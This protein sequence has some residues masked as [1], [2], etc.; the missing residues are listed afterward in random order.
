MNIS[1]QL[2]Q[3]KETHTLFYFLHALNPDIGKWGGRR[4]CV[5]DR[6]D[7]LS[8]NDIVKR[9]DAVYKTSAKD[10]LTDQKNVMELIKKIKNKDLLANQ[11]LVRKGIFIRILTAVKRWVGN[12]GF[13][14]QKILDNIEKEATNSIKTIEDK[15]ERLQKLSIGE[16]V[17]ELMNC[18]LAAKL[19]EIQKQKSAGQENQTSQKNNFEFVEGILSS[20][21]AK[22]FEYQ[23]GVTTTTDPEILDAFAQFK[24]EPEKFKGLANLI[25]RASTW[26]MKDIFK[27]LEDLEWPSQAL[28]EEELP[29]LVGDMQGIN[30]LANETGYVKIENQETF[31]TYRAIVHLRNIFGF[32]FEDINLSTLKISPYLAKGIGLKLHQLGLDTLVYLKENMENNIELKDLKIGLEVVFEDHFPASMIS[33]LLP[34]LDIPGLVSLKLS[35]LLENETKVAA[36]SFVDQDVKP[37]LAIIRQH[38]Y[39]QVVE[40]DLKDMSPEAREQFVKEKDMLLENHRAKLKELFE[41]PDKSGFVEELST[42][43]EAIP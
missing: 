31:A 35:V 40:I 32:G 34:H 26:H 38:H 33:S 37:L 16:L 3:C 39:L 23:W 7:S 12:F 15:M 20:K 8:L 36:K 25:A 1:D 10:D 24:N 5:T 41:N 11:L 22:I 13:N 43:E 27:F 4:F 18:A 28:K 2:N 42:I 9:L 19:A 29:F 17:N 21:I 14:R 6:S 30:L